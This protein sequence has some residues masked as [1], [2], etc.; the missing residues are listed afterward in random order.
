[1]AGIRWQTGEPQGYAGT[2]AS[3]RRSGVPAFGTDHVVVRD[4]AANAMVLTAKA[5]ALRPLGFGGSTG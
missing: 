1:M 4:C 3:A 5:T 2:S